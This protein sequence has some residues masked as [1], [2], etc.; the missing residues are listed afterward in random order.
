MAGR[1]MEYLLKL[2]QAPAQ[3]EYLKHKQNKILEESAEDPNKL[4]FWI[5]S[6]LQQL[7]VGGDWPFIRPLVVPVDS[8]TPNITDLLLNYTHLPEVQ[9]FFNLLLTQRPGNVH[10]GAD[11]WKI[12]IIG[13][14]MTFFTRKKKSENESYHVALLFSNFSEIISEKNSENMDEGETDDGKIKNS[15]SPEEEGRTMFIQKLMVS[16]LG[17]EAFFSE[18]LKN[19]SDPVW[20]RDLGPL[21][22]MICGQLSPNLQKTAGTLLDSALPVLSRHLTAGS[23]RS[24]LL[25]TLHTY[26]HRLRC[27]GATPNL[28]HHR[29]FLN[30]AFEICRAEKKFRC[31]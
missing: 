22:G 8:R 18:L 12:L 28:A 29:A 31:F 27:P 3:S 14:M 17:F 21:L 24:L 1:G 26:L 7:Y 11:T 23:P 15:V 4:I 30:R 9:R 25:S 19:F 6:I 5:S 2:L 13:K 10:N 16:P 20:C